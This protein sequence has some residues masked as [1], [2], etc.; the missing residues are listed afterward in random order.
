MD[1][2]TPPKKEAK[3]SKS[4]VVRKTM[5][6]LDES[7]IFTERQLVALVQ[8][9]P[10][11]HIKQRKGRGGKTF[12]YV[13]GSYVQ[14]RLNQV[15]AWSWS[16]EVKDHGNSPSGKSVWVL[17]RLTIIDPLSKNVIVAKEQFGSSDIKTDSSGAEVD[18]A[19]DFKAAATDALK[20]C[21]SLL[22]VA[23]DIYADDETAK[24]IDARVQS[25]VNYQIEKKRQEENEQSR[26]D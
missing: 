17:G 15:F 5:S 26:N 8:K 7:P 18:Y 9:T 20:K 13:S 11:R 10:K 16:F 12:R 6:Y 2:L 1:T 3:S 4:V 24:S 25:V 21:A 23:A 19:D 22:G 14:D